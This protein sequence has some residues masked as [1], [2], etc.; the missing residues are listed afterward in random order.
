MLPAEI[1][2]PNSELSSLPF[3]RE[4]DIG[5]G[6]ALRTFFDE[7][8]GNESKEARAKRLED[9]PKTFVPF[10][11]ALEEDFRNCIDF[12]SALNQGVQTLDVKELPAV[13]KAEWAKAQKYLENRPF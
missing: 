8:D 5:L 11:E 4:P 9:F 12:V 1:V 10:A 6:I 13:D 2:L 7:D 3:L